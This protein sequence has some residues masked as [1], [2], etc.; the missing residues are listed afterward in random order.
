M[1][2]G[3]IESLG[4]VAEV[5]PTASGFRVRISTAIA[6]ELALGESVSVNGVCLT[7]VGNTAGSMHADVAPETARVTTL[8]SLVA[9]SPVN[10]ERSMRADARIGGHFVQGHVDATGSITAIVPEGESYRLTVSFPAV[11]GSLIVSKGSIA[12][13]GISLTVA[14]VTTDRFDIQVI[15]FTWTHTNLS[16]LNSGSAVNLEFDIL[17]KY[18][19]RALEVRR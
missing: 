1:F 8:G 6:G 3:L 9:G 7:V 16:Q 17:G 2:T 5:E 15:P 18:V 4:H 19:A 11:F 14:S 12:V 10:L 13:D